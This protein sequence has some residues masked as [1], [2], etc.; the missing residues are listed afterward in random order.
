MR[1]VTSER[2]AREACAK[3]IDDVGI[4]EE[5]VEKGL[6]GLRGVRSAELE[7]DDPNFGLLAHAANECAS[8]ME[9]LVSN[10]AEWERCNEKPH[11]SQTETWGTHSRTADPSPT[12]AQEPR[13]RV[14]DDS[15]RQE[16]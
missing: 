12:F 15:K 1:D 14:R 10:E 16:P 4:A 5:I 2:L 8:G 7:Q 9:M 13:D 6:D 3:E 11:A